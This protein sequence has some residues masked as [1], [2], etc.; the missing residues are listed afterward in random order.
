MTSPVDTISYTETDGVAVITLNRPSAS[1][2]LDLAM[3][4]QL[5]AVLE[6][7]SSTPTVRAV[8]IAASGKNFCVGQDLAEHVT[9]LH[10]DP[11]HAMDTVVEHYNPIVR[12]LRGIRVP[13]VAGINGA[14]VGAGLG[15]A[16]A[17][18][19][20]IAGERAKFGTAFTGIGL[21]SDSGLSASLTELVGKGRALAL[22]LLGETLDATTAENWGLVNR[23]VPDSEVGEQAVAMAARLAVGPTAAYAAVKELVSSVAG[24]DLD[25]VLDREAEAQRLLGASSDHR[26]AVDAFLAKQQP[27]FVGR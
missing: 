27:T 23:V 16:L 22:F 10:A 8:S 20:R 25:T 4:E 2:A 21:A 17:A 24:A 15:L 19:I 5:L 7:V 12:A 9:G 3:K 11:A 26:A 6:A 18:D 13:V 1:N 14:C